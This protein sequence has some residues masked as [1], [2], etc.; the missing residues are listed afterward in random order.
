MTI[1]VLP[2]Q[3][4]THLLSYSLARFIDC[5]VHLLSS[6]DMIEH[7]PKKRVF[8]KKYILKI[9]LKRMKTDHVI[10]VFSLLVGC[11]QNT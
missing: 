9:V 2:E 10:D 11:A 4:R 3:F 8:Q 5:S 1:T 6:I 7:L